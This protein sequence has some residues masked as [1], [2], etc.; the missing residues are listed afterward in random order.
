MGFMGFTRVLKLDAYETCEIMLDGP[1][2]AF[3]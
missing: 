1:E 3:D 2:K